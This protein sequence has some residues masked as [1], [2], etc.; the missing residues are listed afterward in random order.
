MA[1]KAEA[2]KRNEKDKN[3]MG[4]GRRKGGGK[5]ENGNPPF[6]VTLRQKQFK[7]QFQSC[8]I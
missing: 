3:Q 6:G 2:W 4:K 1:E 5:P 7:R 8:R